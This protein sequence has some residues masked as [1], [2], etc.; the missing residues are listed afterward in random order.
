MHT[1]ALMT[2]EQAFA[3]QYA[4]TALPTPKPDQGYVEVSALEAGL[5]K[6]PSHL[7]VEGSGPNEV[8]TCPTLA[9]F[10]RHV[11]SG[12]HLLFDLGLRRDT[13]TFPPSVLSTIARYMPVEVPQT[14]D[15]SLAKGG[16]DAQDVQTIVLSHLHF[17]Q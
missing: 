7:F 9:F 17:D 13:T 4:A 5:I 8:H 2:T 16:F 15:E 12:A 14:V 11:P 6:L 10:I 3:G 1:E